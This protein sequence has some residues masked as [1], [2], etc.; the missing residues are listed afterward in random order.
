MI[1]REV[2]TFFSSGS[3][4]ASFLPLAAAT[5][6][7]YEMTFF[8]FSVFPAPDSP[9]STTHVVRVYNTATVSAGSVRVAVLPAPTVPVPLDT[10]QE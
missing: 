9:L 8:V 2:K 6:A 5:S 3:S 1:E 4:V 7:K 10:H